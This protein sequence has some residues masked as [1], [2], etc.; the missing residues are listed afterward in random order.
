M[1]F[2]LDENLPVEAAEVLRR[3][4]YDAVT[5]LEQ[6]LGGVADPEVASVCQNEGRTL[7]TLDTVSS[8]FK[9]AFIY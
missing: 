7:I 4:G 3:V 8:H 2:K 9:R 5:V 6:N 1:E